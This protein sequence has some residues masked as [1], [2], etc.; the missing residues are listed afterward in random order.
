MPL[1]PEQRSS[2]PR[3]EGLATAAIGLFRNGDIGVMT[4]GVASPLAAS[5]SASFSKSAVIFENAYE[6]MPGQWVGKNSTR[7]RLN[8]VA[9]GGPNGVAFSVALNTSPSNCRI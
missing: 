3:H 1:L 4:N 6:N 8:I 7:T 2:Q 9:D 5:V